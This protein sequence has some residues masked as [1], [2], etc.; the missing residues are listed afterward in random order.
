MQDRT[1]PHAIEKAREAPP[2]G[3]S[4]E[5]AAVAVA[6]VLDTVGDT[7]PEGLPEI[8]LTG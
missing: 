6:E 1:D 4:H 8:G 7:C 5:T 3:V 2:A